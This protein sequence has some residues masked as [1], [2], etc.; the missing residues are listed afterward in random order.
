MQAVFFVGVSFFPALILISRFAAL[1]THFLPEV[2]T[3]LHWDIL[4]LLQ[5]VD[6]APSTTTSTQFLAQSQSPATSPSLC[7]T[8]H[9]L[10]RRLSFLFDPHYKGLVYVALLPYYCLRYHHLFLFGYLSHLFHNVSFAVI[11]RPAC[12]SGLSLSFCGLVPGALQKEG[13]DLFGCAVL[14]CFGWVRA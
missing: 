7:M 12:Q 6:I 2:Y 3:C 8:V 10:N 11:I 1:S 4:S 9:Y 5:H 14:F 13:F